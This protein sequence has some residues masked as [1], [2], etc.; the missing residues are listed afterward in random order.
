MSNRETT[1]DII[2]RFKTAAT[3]GPPAVETVDASIAM[4]EEFI[5]AA[6]RVNDTVPDGRWKSLALTAL[7]EALMWAN[8]GLFNQPQPTQQGTPMS[9]NHAVR[10]LTDWGAEHG[11]WLVGRIRQVE[12][13]DAYDIGFVRGN[14]SSEETSTRTLRLGGQLL[15]EGDVKAMLA[16][17]QEVLS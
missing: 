14:A 10:I 16:L 1:Q 13:R 17:A 12:D 5:G 4:R 9:L 8:K 7:E 6:I 11:G 3:S 15:A 2:D